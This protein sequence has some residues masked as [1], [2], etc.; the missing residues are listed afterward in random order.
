MKAQMFQGK[1]RLVRHLNG[2]ALEIKELI[3]LIFHLD[4]HLV[5]NVKE[6]GT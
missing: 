5:S 4:F 1:N 3:Q 6:T 2:L